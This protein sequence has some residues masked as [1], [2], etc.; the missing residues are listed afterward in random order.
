MSWIRAGLGHGLRRKWRSVF[1]I[2]SRI[3]LPNFIWIKFIDALYFS[4]SRTRVVWIKESGLFRLD[5]RTRS[6]WIARRT[7]LEWYLQGIEKRFET[8][9]REYGLDWTQ[10]TGSRHKGLL[11]VD[12][13]ANVGE[14]SLI[15][16]EM[17]F[18]VIAIEPDPVEFGALRKNL[19]LSARCIRAALWSERKQMGLYLRNATGD[20]SLI[21]TGKPDISIR[22]TTLDNVLNVELTEERRIAVIKLEAEGAEPEILR[23]AQVSLGRTDWVTVD[24]GPERGD[25]AASTLPGVVAAMSAAGFVFEQVRLPRLTAQ[26]AAQNL[27][28]D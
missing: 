2:Y 21:G 11:A 26:F 13:G 18:E 14:V 19:G 8:L 3:A 24:A 6:I 15:L 17:G 22:A 12:V 20:T 16:Q 23:G 1:S 7:R 10:K 4:V 25:E 5:Q 9:A 28:V 27:R